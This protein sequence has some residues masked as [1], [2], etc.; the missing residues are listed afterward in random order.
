MWFCKVQAR[1]FG[2]LH[3]EEDSQL[4][5]APG[6][7]IVHGPNEAGKSSW[8]AALSAALCGRRRGRGRKNEDAA[9]AERHRPWSSGDDGPW[10][11][12]VEIEQDDGTRL[13]IDRDFRLGETTIN[14]PKLGDRRLSDVESKITHDGSPDGALLVG[15]SRNTFAM[16]AS[17]R[18][19]SIISD[20]ENPDALREQLARAAARSDDAT[21][22]SA[23]ARIDEYWKQKVGDQARARTKP[24]RKAMDAQAAAK[25]T[26]TTVKRRQRSYLSDVGELKS[27]RRRV[28]DLQEKLERRPEA[29]AARGQSGPTMARLERCSARMLIAIG[30]GLL[31]AVVVGAVVNPEIGL[32]AS[33]PTAFVAL[34]LANRLNVGGESDRVEETSAADVT[35]D[36]SLLG[37]AQSSTDDVEPDPSAVEYL[38]ARTDQPKSETTTAS[39]YAW[40]P[41]VAAARA[42]V[43]KAMDEASQERSLAQ[44]KCKIEAAR[45]AVLR[46]DGALRSVDSADLDVAAAESALADANERLGRVRQ[47]DQTLKTTERFMQQ[48][49]NNAHRV[50][51]PR[52]EAKVS[53][54]VSQVTNG[55]YRSVLVDPADL[56]VRL[57]TASGERRDARDVS[58][59]TTEQVYLVLRTILAEVLSAGRERCPL[60]L[61]DVTVHADSDRKAAIL[62]CLHEVAK[63]RQVILFSQEQQVREWARSRM[64]DGVH[65]IELGLAQPA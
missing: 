27:L 33:I 31:T 13:R 49:A 6:L 32:V 55:R 29:L 14:D 26:L 56:G 1:A 48:A 64:D 17:V 50:L 8:H 44:L 37:P 34:L 61:D 7:N 15:L 47:L 11:V 57:V 53:T 4:E 9:F 39:V 63:E 12:A 59:G 58:R 3:S 54:L 19:A 21:A 36:G 35:S 45:D 30:V 46:A 5:F 2:P 22:A 62:E 65:L 40:Q 23:L 52:I 16:A 10:A 51:A 18:Q 38:R 42:A 41:L 60:L 20:L 24:L 43:Q 28:C 25:E